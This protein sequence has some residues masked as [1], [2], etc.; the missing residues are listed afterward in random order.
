MRLLF[1][2]CR[3]WVSKLQYTTMVAPPHHTG[4]EPCNTNKKKQHLQYVLMLTSFKK[5]LHLSYSPSDDIIFNN[6]PSYTDCN[7]YSINY[8]KTLHRRATRLMTKINGGLSFPC[9]HCLEGMVDCG[10]PT[11]HF[12]SVNCSHIKK[13]NLSP[14]D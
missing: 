10:I 1:S 7:Y 6:V 2:P 8:P 14:F 9:F 4:R 13:T 3:A 5:K 11:K 12:F